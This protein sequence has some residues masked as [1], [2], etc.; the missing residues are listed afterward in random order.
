MTTST[1]PTSHGF[2][3]WRLEGRTEVPRL[4]VW[5]PWCCR[6]QDHNLDDAKPGQTVTRAVHCIAMDNTA[7]T[8]A[9][10]V[11]NTPFPRVRSTVRESTYPQFRAI[12]RGVIS[13]VVRTLRAQA[14]PVGTVHE[15]AR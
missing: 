15:V 4:R 11:T 9:I 1:E 10:L 7:D 8:Y 5:C 2:I 6:W 12:R 3:E 14:R 13:P